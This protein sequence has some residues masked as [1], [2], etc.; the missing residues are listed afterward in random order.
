MSI[1]P[2]SM[3]TLYNWIRPQGHPPLTRL[4]F[5]LKSDSLAEGKEFDKSPPVDQP[6]PNL[7][8][9]ANRSKYPVTICLGRGLLVLDIES[10][11][12]NAGNVSPIMTTAE[13]IH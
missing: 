13:P 2:L 7:M 3:V 12:T 8:L 11:K 6:Y 10:V 9:P 1:Y 4:I 5:P